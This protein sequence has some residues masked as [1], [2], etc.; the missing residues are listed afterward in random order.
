MLK[1]QR[2]FCRILLHVVT[3]IDDQFLQSYACHMAHPSGQGQGYGRINCLQDHARRVGPTAFT[4]FL[5]TPGFTI[6]K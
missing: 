3:Y 2:T 1:L 5:A 4:E 6:L